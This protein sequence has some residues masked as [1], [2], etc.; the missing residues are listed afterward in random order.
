VRGVSSG[1]GPSSEVGSQ[2]RRESEGARGEKGDRER[3]RERESV[4][5]CVDA[6]ERAC[7]CE[8]E[9][10]LARERRQRWLGRRCPKRE[11]REQEARVRKIER[12]TQRKVKKMSSGVAVWQAHGSSVGRSKAHK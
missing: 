5:V 11:R 1:G 12:K 4:C 10:V 7:A 8:C 3:Q 2:S 6:G 9:T